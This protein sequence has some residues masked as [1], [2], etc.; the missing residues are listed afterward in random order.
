MATGGEKY[1][2]IFNFEQVRACDGG[3][4]GRLTALIAGVPPRLCQGLDG[5]QLGVSLLLG[6]R[7]LSGHGLRGPSLHDRQ[8][9]FREPL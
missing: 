8:V 9:S 3:G 7:P 2:Y 6:H 5:G 1:S 4:G